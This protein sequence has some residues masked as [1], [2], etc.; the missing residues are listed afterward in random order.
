[1]VALG[2]LPTVDRGDVWMVERGKDFSLA[3]K[4][5]QPLRFLGE[6]IGRDFD[7]DIPAELSVPGSRIS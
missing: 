5:S 6:L 7:R 4:S 2:L 3:L 1:M